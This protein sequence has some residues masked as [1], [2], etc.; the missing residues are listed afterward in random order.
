MRI[1]RGQGTVDHFL[2][3]AR[4]PQLAYEW[5]NYRLARARLNGSKGASEDVMDPFDVQEGWFVLDVPSCLIFPGDDLDGQRRAEVAVTID[6]LELNGNDL[7]RERAEWL[8]D[9]AKER[10]SIEDVR[11]SYPF[12]AF[13]VERQGIEGRLR[14]LFGLS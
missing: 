3:K 6:V 7:A 9:L 14:T 10:H 4:H 11:E 13:E 5:D 8:V 12:L 2:P 1:F